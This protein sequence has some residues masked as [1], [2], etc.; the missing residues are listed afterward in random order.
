MNIL[1][2]INKNEYNFLREDE[3][4]KNNICLLTL[5]G[6]YSYGTNKTDGTSDVDIRGIAI[7]SIDEIIGIKK[8]WDTYVDNNTDT[9]IYSFKKIVNLLTSCNPNTIEIVGCRS[10]DYI[11]LSD[12]GKMI[13]DNKNIFL[14][15]RAIG[16]FRGYANQQF[17]RM[18]NYYAKSSKTAEIMEESMLRS[19]E[20][21]MLHF[22]KTYSHYYDGLMS[23]RLQDCNNDELNQE[24]V[25]D[26][27]TIKGLPLREINSL[28]NDFN[29]VL[30]DYTK[31]TINHRNK[32]L[33]NEKLAKHQMH[34][35]RLYFML[36]DILK[37][38]EIRTYREKEHDFLMNVRDGCF[39]NEDN[40]IS[41]EL[42]EVKTD[43]EKEV[44]YAIKNTAL[45]K[46][47]DEN[48]INEFV[49]SVNKKVLSQYH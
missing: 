43:L 27:E 12:I 23:L 22:N 32:K 13:L 38:E 7:N 15:Q 34:L 40:S 29:S 8:D 16:S 28:L 26:I 24:V 37:N 36:L 14:S 11:Y 9:V 6:S 33:T 3:K 20:N 46:T 19:C 44:S 5:G 35:F 21:K 45:R 31:S 48:L 25:I 42:M 17:N 39:I 2:E 10:Q 30:R 47:P 41:S 49:M 18:F 4:L 1:N